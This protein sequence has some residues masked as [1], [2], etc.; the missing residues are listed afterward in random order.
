[1]IALSTSPPCGE[2]FIS[3]PV[4]ARYTLFSNAAISREERGD[5]VNSAHLFLVVLSNFSG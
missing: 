4:S 1:M 2:V 3:F 5:T